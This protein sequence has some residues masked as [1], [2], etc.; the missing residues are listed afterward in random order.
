MWTLFSIFP[1]LTALKCTI[2][3]ISAFTFLFLHSLDGV[4]P[5]YSK[6]PTMSHFLHFGREIVEKQLLS[7]GLFE[8]RRPELVGGLS[9]DEDQLSL[10]RRQS[11]VHTHLLPLAT[12]PNSKPAQKGSRESDLFLVSPRSHFLCHLPEDPR[13]FVLGPERLVGG[14]DPVEEALRESDA[15]EAWGE[16]VIA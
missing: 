10:H 2:H 7:V 15:A 8:E 14:Y 4:E 16:P 9:V 3:A 11:V 1:A 12:P 6:F 5:R 13:V